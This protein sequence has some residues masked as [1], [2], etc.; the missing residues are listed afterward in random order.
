MT[1]QTSS[2]GLPQSLPT[3]LEISLGPR[4]ETYLV[5]MLTSLAAAFA[6]R[7]PNVGVCTCE[8]GEKSGSGSGGG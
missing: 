1:D 3:K 6:M 2:S 4:V 7:R 8:C 5:P